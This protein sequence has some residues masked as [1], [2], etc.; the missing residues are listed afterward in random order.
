M[1]YSYKE[2]IHAQAGDSPAWRRAGRD[3]AGC[4]EPRDCVIPL[5]PFQ[6]PANRQIF[7]RVSAVRGLLTCRASN[8]RGLVGSLAAGDIAMPIR[9]AEPLL[10]ALIGG[11]E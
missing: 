9:Q 3:A 8:A 2:A 4:A 6:A 11:A 5:A 10:E 1:P 7:Y